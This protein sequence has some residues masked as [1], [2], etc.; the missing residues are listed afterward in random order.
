M[1]PLL[2]Y[3]DLLL[4]AVL[5]LINVVLSLML[6][7]GVGRALFI[8]ACR[9]AA[10]LLLVGFILKY[11]F[12]S[13]SPWLI[14][15]VAC[16]MTTLAAYE[17]WSRQKTRFAGVW[18]VGVG[19]VATGIAV[20]LVMTYTMLAIV[21]VDPW[22]TPQ[23]LI[24]F[25]GIILGSVMNGVGISLNVFNTG[26]IRERAAIEAQ[27]ALGAT[28]REALKPLQSHALRSGFIPIVNQMSAAGVI[29]L[30]G[31]MTGQILAGMPPYEAAKYQIL[32]LF[33]L[34]GA[35]GFGALAA[36]ALAVRRATDSRDRLRLDRMAPETS[37]SN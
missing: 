20:V 9:A 7:L 30:P 14:L 18:G 33:L 8:A 4:G 25:V 24:P 35:A 23:L 19:A 11:V 28:R 3:T 22:Y 16:V 37:S 32:V 26:L 13:S 31:M 36:T 21:S 34:A 1:T 5:V 10:Q 29:T 2:T 12:E 6:N 27:L 17:V 15:G